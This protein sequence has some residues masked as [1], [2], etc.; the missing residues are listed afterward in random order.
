VTVVNEKQPAYTVVLTHDVDQL[1]L[2]DAPFASRI[3][4]S[5]L[6]RCIISNFKRWLQKDLDAL[7]YWRSFLSGLS[8]PLI[9]ARIV[10]DPMEMG[11]YKAM[12][13]EKQYN[14]RSTFFF[15]PEKG[16]PGYIEK[17][18]PAPARR[19]TDYDVRD[20]A[21]LLQELEQGG[22]EVGIHGINAHLGQQEAIDELKVF[23]NLIPGKKKWG[24]RMHWLFQPDMLWQNL[25]EA[26]YYYDATFGSNDNTG[27]FQGRFHPFIK[28][29]IRVLPLT[30]QD[31]TLLAHW[32]GDMSLEAAWPR[33]RGVLDRAKEHR[34]V[35]TVLW[36]T[37]S[38]SAPRYW[39]SLYHR[40]IRQ[41]LDDGAQFLTAVRAVE[42]FT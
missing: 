25:H 21:E 27:F 31:G 7:T 42:Q 6:K 40:I 11:L 28:D 20:Y 19:G 41:G 38:F 9:K 22:W 35:V 5:Y 13:I 34:A 18:K 17:G 23:Q 24:M 2:R 4:A 37:A 14:V 8:F 29:N 15:L 33:V 10:S 16:N 39:E 1:A 32:R 30:I 36:H 3:A 26:G 12:E